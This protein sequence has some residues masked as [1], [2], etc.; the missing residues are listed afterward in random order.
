MDTVSN[1]YL[2]QMEHDMLME[3]KKVDVMNAVR[4][5]LHKSPSLLVSDVA[6]AIAEVLAQDELDE[7]IVGLQNAYAQYEHTSS[8][9]ENAQPE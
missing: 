4:Y 8:G 6:V 2:D 1:N 7:L 5:A 3:S 9:R